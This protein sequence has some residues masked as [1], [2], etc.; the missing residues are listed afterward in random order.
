M[1]THG[2]DLGRRLAD[3]DMATVEAL[4]N[5]Y[6]VAGENLAF[7]DV[8]KQLAVT[9]LMPFFDGGYAVEEPRDV[10]KTFRARFG[11]EFGVHIRPF[12]ILARSSIYKAVSYTHLDV[13][14]RQVWNAP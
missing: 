14:K 13:Y 6:A 12:I 1:R 9:L 5:A 8:G 4:P 10:F 7:V 2:A 11:S 3:M